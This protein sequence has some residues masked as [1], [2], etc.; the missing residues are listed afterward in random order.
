MLATWVP[1]GGSM[2]H[3]WDAYGAQSSITSDLSENYLHVR[4]RLEIVCIFGARVYR[5]RL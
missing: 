2:G 3:P 4:Q 1:M 5:I